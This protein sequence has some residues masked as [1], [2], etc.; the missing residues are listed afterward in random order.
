MTID[1]FTI[2]SLEVGPLPAC[3]RCHRGDRH[4]LAGWLGLHLCGDCILIAK[5]RHRA[6]AS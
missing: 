2:A 1:T 5:A 3:D 6:V 4:G